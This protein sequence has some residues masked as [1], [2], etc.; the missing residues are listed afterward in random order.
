MNNKWHKCEMHFV[1]T[2]RNVMIYFNHGLISKEVTN[3]IPLGGN[4]FNDNPVIIL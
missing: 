4:P 1:D 2:S 3:R